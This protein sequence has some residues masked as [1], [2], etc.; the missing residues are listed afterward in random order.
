MSIAHYAAT[1]TGKIDPGWEEPSMVRLIELAGPGDHS[2]R[3]SA[4]K[5]TLTTARLQNAKRY[6]AAE[7]LGPGRA[8]GGRRPLYG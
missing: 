3:G 1:L 5:F 7:L 6:I 2:G 8:C 4:R